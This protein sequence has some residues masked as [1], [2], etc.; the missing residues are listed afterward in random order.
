[1]FPLNCSCANA[2]YRYDDLAGMPPGVRVGMPNGPFR[3][4]YLVTLS[5]FGDAIRRNMQAV[6]SSTQAAAP[7]A[8]QAALQAQQ[9]QQRKDLLAEMPPEARKAVEQLFPK[10]S[11]LNAIVDQDPNVFN[12]RSVAE[13]AVFAF[14]S[15]YPMTYTYT[16]KPLRRIESAKGTTRTGTTQFKNGKWIGSPTQI[17]QLKRMER[18]IVDAVSRYVAARK[19]VLNRISNAIPYKG[20]VIRPVITGNAVQYTVNFNISK[21][22]G[23][24]PSPEDAKAAIDNEVA[25]GPGGVEAKEAFEQRAQ[26]VGEEKAA[27]EIIQRQ[28]AASAPASEQDAP[29][30]PEPAGGGLSTGAKIGIAA[31]A[32][33]GA[34]L[35]MR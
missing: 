10:P 34:F 4:G 5:G 20:H 35:L 23:T 1:M 26:E 9:E 12:A 6:A 33:G 28:Q 24:F 19:A 29:T 2:R 18:N 16:Q 31:A 32:V 11:P 30:A 3:Q 15:A 7:A 13:Q 22:V 21:K 17:E 8:Q 27:Q 25:F 14:Q